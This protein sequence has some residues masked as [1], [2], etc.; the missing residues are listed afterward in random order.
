M[1]GAPGVAGAWLILRAFASGC[2]AMT[3]VEAVSNG[4]PLVIITVAKFA[5]GA[6]ITLVAGPALV[7]LFWAIRRH[8]QAVA[9]E[10][11]W[12]VELNTREVSSPLVIIPFDTWNCVTELALRV[13]LQM[14]HNVTAVHVT[15]EKDHGRLRGLWAEQVE[16]PAQAAR[17]P[18][19]RLEIIQSPYRKLYEPILKFVRKT[20][21]ENEDRLIAVIIPEL[22]EAHWYEFLLHNLYAAILRYLLLAEGDRRTIVIMTRWQIS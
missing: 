3:G 11:D 19:P 4:V 20:R 8:Y 5:E 14:S 18:A 7:W 1:A 13:G 22:V 2:T 21:R 9:G 12:P 17:I 10:I 6:W 16:K 15:T